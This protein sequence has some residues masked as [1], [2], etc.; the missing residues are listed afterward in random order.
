MRLETAHDCPG[1]ILTYLLDQFALEAG[2][3]AGGSYATASAV[4]S[5]ARSE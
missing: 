4:V 2:L 5:S 1:E 3:A